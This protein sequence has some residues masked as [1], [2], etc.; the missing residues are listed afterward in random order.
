M[1]FL[2]VISA[3]G[4]SEVLKML[5]SHSHYVIKR[6]FL[7][8]F[9]KEGYLIILAAVFGMS[10]TD[11]WYLISTIIRTWEVKTGIVIHVTFAHVKLYE[12]IE[13]IVGNENIVDCAISRKRK[14]DFTGSMSK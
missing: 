9:L 8:F 12:K 10:E 1:M 6:H 3:L 7:F 14:Y 5:V 4:L 13:M 2:A 11:N